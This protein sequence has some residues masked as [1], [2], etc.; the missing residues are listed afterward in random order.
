VEIESEFSIV[1][2]K[3]DE[4]GKLN[5]E[6]MPEGPNGEELDYLASSEELLGKSVTFCIRVPEANNLPAKYNNDCH[7]SFA[8][9]GETKETEMCETKTSNPKFKFEA[10]FK[11]ENVNEEFRQY[12]LKEAA[13]FEVKG[14]SETQIKEAVEEKK[15]AAAAAMNNQ[16][17]A[18]FTDAADKAGSNSQCTQCEENL[19]AWECTD[20]QKD[21]CD[22]CFNLLHK[23]AKKANH[24]KV[25]LSAA[26]VGASGAVQCAQCEEKSAVVQCQDCDKSLCEGC[27]ALLHKSA[28]KAEH[29]RVAL[30][31]SGS[32]AVAPAAAAV[33][34]AKPKCEQCEEQES[35]VKC[36]DCIKSLCDGCNALLHKSAKKASHA[37]I[38]Y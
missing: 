11:V 9:N 17:K 25:A 3:G 23:S 28:K 18:N 8:F 33:S 27:N 14:F 5:V 13:V 6:I 10:K 34:I 20:C 4:Q 38:A 32:A 12:L 24:N 16:S 15:E 2:Y 19:A 22:A 37:R 1:D 36:N 29:V 26:A 31:S 35:T 30:S 7:V 21:L